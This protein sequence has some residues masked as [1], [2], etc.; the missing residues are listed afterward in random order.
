MTH[1]RLLMAVTL[2]S[3]WLLGSAAAEQKYPTRTIT[4]VV[5]FAAGGPSDTITRIIADRLGNQLGQR[6][7]V[8]N[9]GGAGGTIG[10]GRVVAAAPDGYTLLSHHIGLSTEPSLY[11]SLSFDPLKD[12]APIALFAESPMAIVA[13][14][15]F[16]P[17]TLQELIQFIRQ[18]QQKI[19]YANAGIGSATFLCGLLFEQ[20][21][22]AKFTY[23]PY[24]GSGPAYIDLLAGR[25][26]IMCDLTTG[27]DGYI[28]SGQLKAYA[29]TADKRVP[30]LPDVPTTEEVGLPGF[31]MSVWYGLYAP[32]NT[33]APIIQQ[34]SK[35]MQVIVQDKTVA[36]RFAQT[37]TY[38]YT[39]EQ[40]TPEALHQ[41]L[42]EQINLWNPII[43]ESGVSVN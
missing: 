13:P 32:A 29:V 5:P 23:I 39:P 6:V 22:N 33:P 12:L 15:G 20:H 30:T 2:A 16:P 41:R 10:T 25:T 26:N 7:I 28:H 24:T 42:K 34:L 18:P 37:D 31:K 27:L 19:T 40:A 4:I 43:L 35:A 1:L 38:L 14:K 8:Q 21:I 11:K 3:A 36:E 17:N 9:Y